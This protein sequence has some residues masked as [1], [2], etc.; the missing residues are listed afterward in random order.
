MPSLCVHGEVGG[1]PNPDPNPNPNP[2]PTPTPTPTPNPNQ[3]LWDK[4]LGCIVSND[5]WSILKMFSTSFASL[6]ATPRDLYPAALAPQI[7]ERHSHI[8]RNL[9]NAVYIAGIG[10]LKQNSN[11]KPQP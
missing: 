3:V 1:H 5:S 9:L 4:H 10:I 6:A 8:Y 2:N 7:E 11:S